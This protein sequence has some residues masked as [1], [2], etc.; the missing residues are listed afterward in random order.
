MTNDQLSLL[1]RQVRRDII[2]MVT[3]A[4][5]G[6]PGGSL[7]MADIF[8]ALYA[9]AMKHNPKNWPSTDNTD[10]FFLSNGHISPVWYSILSRTG[11]F[12]LSELGTFRKIHTRLQGH[13]ATKEKLPGVRIASGSLGQGLSV[14]VGAALALKL[15]KRTDWV[16]CLMGDGEC[17]EGQI[18]EAAMN[19]PHQQVDNLIAFVDRNR[20][21]IDGSTE[22]V[23]K[24]DPFPDKWKAFGWNVLEIDGHN[25]DD[26]FSAIKKAKSGLGT[27]KPTVII[28][29]TVMGKGVPFMEN[30][31]KWHGTPPSKQME[32][33]AL[34]QHIL[35]TP[36][37][38]YDE[39]GAKA[40]EIEG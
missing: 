4:N 16:Y 3:N 26:I 27:G 23:K 32:I 38:D 7:G 36:F 37:L 11:Y 8:T 22:I 39:V 35:P 5:S 40:I 30:D 15:D 10:L 17:N 6:H 18:W 19:A 12:P 33:D 13:P 21:Q 1:A 14:A 25:F 34:T 9:K 29:N 24:L 31:A 20:L 28:A 2:K